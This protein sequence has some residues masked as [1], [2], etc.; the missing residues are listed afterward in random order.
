MGNYLM[1]LNIKFMKLNK[2]NMDLSPMNESLRIIYF[3]AILKI[4]RIIYLY[5]SILFGCVFLN[6]FLLVIQWAGSAFLSRI[7]KTLE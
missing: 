2:I 5:D 1:L 3:K 4:V 7:L 6:N